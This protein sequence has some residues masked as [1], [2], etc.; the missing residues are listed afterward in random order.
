MLSEKDKARVRKDF[1]EWTGG[2]KASEVGPERLDVYVELAMPA[3][4]DSVEV[5][6]FLA[7]WA[8]R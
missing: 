5:E 8:N 1:T 3:D 2:Y 7:E 6:A 4:L